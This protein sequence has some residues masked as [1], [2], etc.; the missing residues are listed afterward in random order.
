MLV[1]WE[2]ER[3]NRWRR[4]RGESLMMESGERERCGMRVKDLERGKKKEKRNV[5]R[6]GK[7]EGEKWRE[8]R[9]SF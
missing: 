4:K 6:E 2:R 3:K 5:E 9:F 7:K 8:N 1:S